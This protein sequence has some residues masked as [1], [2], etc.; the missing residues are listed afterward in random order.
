MG[1]FEAGGFVTADELAELGVQKV[2]NA[3]PVGLGDNGARLPATS[4]RKNP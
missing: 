3:F 2:M 4:L 1:F